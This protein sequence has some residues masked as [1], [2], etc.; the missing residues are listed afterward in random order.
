MCLLELPKVPVR[1]MPPAVTRS[2]TTQI[3]LML[4]AIGA[5]GALGILAGIAT[6][7]RGEPVGPRGR[8]A[9]TT[10]IA[11]RTVDPPETPLRS[12]AVPTTSEVAAED[13]RQ[14]TA[15]TS[16]SLCLVVNVSDQDTGHPL[17]AV[18][19]VWS[20]G[21]PLPWW[22]PGNGS[23]LVFLARATRSH[24]FCL[25]SPSFLLASLPFAPCRT[26]LEGRP[27]SNQA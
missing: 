13:P 15:A 17:E 19:V 3:V 1:A 26:F 8:D 7:D 18:D 16:P 23:E 11:P 25:W 2:R 20:P 21:Q 22:H 9:V 6:R 10:A 27:A 5:V 4:T 24:T 14:P 12:L